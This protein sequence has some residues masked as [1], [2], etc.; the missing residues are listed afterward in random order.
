MLKN[1]YI[2]TR[3]KKASHSGRQAK[4]Q[5]P[6]LTVILL[7]LMNAFGKVHHRLIA[8][9]LRS[10]IPANQYTDCIGDLYLKLDSTVVIQAYRIPFIPVRKG[11]LQGDFPSLPVF[12][13]AINTFIQYINLISLLSSAHIV[14]GSY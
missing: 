5:Q 3:F 9:A 7:D 13:M 14:H 12:N 8:V 11:V 2:E 6:S 1:E 10:Q 4:K